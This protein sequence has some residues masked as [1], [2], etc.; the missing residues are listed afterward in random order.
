M[1]NELVPRLLW[2]KARAPCSPLDG[3]SNG[4]G[5]KLNHQGTAGFSLC[6]HLPWF[7]VGTYIDPNQESLTKLIFMANWILVAR[8]RVGK[9]SST[10]NVGTK[11]GARGGKESKHRFP[12]GKIDGPGRE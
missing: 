10:G 3:A 9:W 1:R 4:Y 7:I 11:K 2:T 6:F 5:S 12:F 8:C